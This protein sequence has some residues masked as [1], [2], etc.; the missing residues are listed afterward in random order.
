ME[1]LCA[2]LVPVVNL[3]RMALAEELSCIEAGR[4]SAEQKKMYKSRRAFLDCMEAYMQS[5]NVGEALASFLETSGDIKLT[6]HMLLRSRG[7]I[8]E[9]D[10][11]T[12][13]RALNRAISERKRCAFVCKKC[14]LVF[15]AFNKPIECSRCKCSDVS[16]ATR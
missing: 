10:R 3:W 7:N 12:C 16:S 13:V 15:E 1:Q 6:K 5:N 8:A 14:V 11:E 4:C 9:D 2:S